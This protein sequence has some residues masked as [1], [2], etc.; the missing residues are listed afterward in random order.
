ML[1]FLFPRVLFLLGFLP[2][3]FFLQN[4]F[5]TWQNQK[6]TVFAQDLFHGLL[7]FPNPRHRRGNLV[8]WLGVWTVLVLTLARPVWVDPSTES[9]RS[10]VFSLLFVLDASLSMQAEDAVPT[11]LAAAKS[12]FSKLAQALP[13]TP[14]GLIVFEGEAQMACPLTRDHWALGQALSEVRTHRLSQKG[15][16]VEGALNLARIK[17]SNRTGG[18]PVGLVV[19][20]DGEMNQPGN[21]LVAAQGLAEKKIPVFCLGVGTTAGAPILLGRDFWG[22]PVYRVHQGVRVVTHLVPENLQRLALAGRGTYAT[23]QG[24]PEPAV[25]QLA[26]ELKNHPWP[27]GAPTRSGEKSVRELYP[28]GILLTGGALLFLGISGQRRE[29]RSV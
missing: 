27:A 25:R 18:T 8:W 1:Y 5:H 19:V 14:L 17:I 22:K 23:W 26:A 6:Q 24:S 10:E 3:F 9:D 13:D 29:R 21:P 4:R 20:S 12:F 15:S 11:R 7:R 28:G 2:I 16:Q